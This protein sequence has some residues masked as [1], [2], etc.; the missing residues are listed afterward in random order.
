VQLSKAIKRK[1][2]R[3]Q[4]LPAIARCYK[5]RKNTSEKTI[6]QLITAHTCAERFKLEGGYKHGTVTF[7]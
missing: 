4:V 6:T 7:K 1:R 2:L 3:Q 5:Q